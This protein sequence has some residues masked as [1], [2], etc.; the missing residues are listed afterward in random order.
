MI[1]RPP[2]STRTDTLLP[3][4]TLFRSLDAIAL[5]GSADAPSYRRGA[6]RPAARPLPWRDG[7]RDAGRQGPQRSAHPAMTTPAPAK[8]NWHRAAQVATFDGRPFI[9]GAA[10]SPR[11][12]ASS[13]PLCPFTEQPLRSEE[14]TSEIQ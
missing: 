9:G 6:G 3:Y 2:R 13:P 4:T 7:Q 5:G 1:R 14:N 12:R 11:S 8:P 10:R